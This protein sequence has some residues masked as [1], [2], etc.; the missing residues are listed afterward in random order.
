M[1]RKTRESKKERRSLQNRIRWV[2]GLVVFCLAAVVAR[3]WFIQIVKHDHFLAC[4]QRQRSSR[5]L[6]TC[7]RG[8]ILAADG[9]R[10]AVTVKG[11]SLFAEPR[12]VKDGK[13]LAKKIAPILGYKVS[14]LEKRLRG[15]RGF[16]WLKR[17][18]TQRQIKA[19]KPW[20]KKEIGLAFSEENQ[21][22][23]PNRELAGQLIGFTDIDCRGQE[24][25]ERYYDKYLKGR[26]VYLSR[27]YDA[28]R[29]VVDNSEYPEL[30][31]YKGKT[32]YL[33]IDRHIQSW[34][35]ETLA[36]A[37]ISSSGR[38]GVALVMDAGSGAFL[39]MAQYPRFNPNSKLK[40]NPALWRNRAVVDLLEPGST[41]KVFTLIAALES[42]CFKLDDKID[43][44]NGRYKVGNR[45]IHD[46]HK[47]GVLRLDEILKYSSNIGCSK[48]VERLGA[49]N[50]YTVLTKFG[51]GDKSGIDYPNEPSGRLRSWRKWHPVDLC[52]LS[53]G[54]GVSLTAVQLT[55][56]YA[57]VANGGYRVTPHLVAKVVNGA[58][59][60]VYEHR[61]Q[62]LPIRV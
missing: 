47:H 13:R 20:C 10:M 21:R 36:Q 23:Y 34:A 61:R 8:E 40:N 37:V 58:G 17:A 46:T 19:L 25:L 7:E 5:F 56:A 55:A 27:E 39:A 59:W 24:G 22:V 62:G 4:Q 57:A 6:L 15:N 14:T 26:Q 16:V 3:A 33:T 43:C 52:N 2:A 31:H 60:T 50:L 18:L 1:K 44:E 41:F 54:Q 53:F 28:K 12:K 48:I 29:K 11:K 42:G 49:E 32:V 51:F 45:I 30:D 35:E 9:G 38:S